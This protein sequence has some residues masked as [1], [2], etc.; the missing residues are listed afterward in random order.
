[1]LFHES[2]HAVVPRVHV[3]SSEIHCI[4]TIIIA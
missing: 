2:H 1:M 3:L 4:E